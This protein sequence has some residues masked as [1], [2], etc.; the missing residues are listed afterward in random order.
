[1]VWSRS[2][3]FFLGLFS[4]AREVG[5]YGLAYGVA[6]MIGGLVGV[7]QQALF[8]A[9]FELLAGDQEARSD[10][11]ASLSIKYL[12]LVFLP[13]CLAMWLFMDSIV[14]LLYGPAYQTVARVFPFV[15]FGTVVANIL[16]PVST[17]IHLSNRKFAA[18]LGIGVVGAVLNIG[19]DLLLIP[20]HHAW[21]AAVANC[22]SQLCVVCIGMTFVA[23]VSP[24]KLDLKALGVVALVN[25]LLGGLF[26]LLLSHANVL[27]LKLSV[28]AVA[29]AVYLR[30][31]AAWGAF[32]ETDRALLAALEEGAPRSL[33][34]LFRL[35][36]GSLGV[37][38]A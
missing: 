10:R 27:A 18:A 8:A 36:R 14:L 6:G 19:L 2:E 5:F 35:V 9:Q 26:W 30:W 11:L 34:P 1:V 12:G 7:S 13:G 20:A 24:V 32:D 17:K 22:I 23:K 16:N 31:L 4:P 29:A 33:R 25:L 21:G 28:A 15:L 37:A 38:A 3:T